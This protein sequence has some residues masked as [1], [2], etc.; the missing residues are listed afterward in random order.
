MA[1]KHDYDKILT[2][3]TVIL[4]KLNDGEALSVK[5][6]AEE[7]NTS[8]RTI[9][10]DFNERLAS[11]PIYQEGKKWKMQDG[12]RVE[13]TKSLE[14]EI[15]LDII[16][17]ITEGIGGTF[18]TKAQKLL[19]KIKN[20][21]FNPIYT[22]LNIEDVSD[23]FSEIQ[24]LETAIK[25]KR[26]VQ[27]SYDNERNDVYTT[28]IQPLKIVNFEGFWY[29]I[30][31]RKDVLKKY[32]LKNI[33]NCSLLE[34]T[35][36]SD[37]ELEDLLDNSISVWFQRDNEPFEVKLYADKAATTY[38]KRRTLPTQ[39]IDSLNSNGTMEFSIRITHEMEILPI[40]KYWIPHLHVIEPIWL[41]DIIQKDIEIYSNMLDNI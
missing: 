40:I 14:D 21:D 7:F 28:T 1:Y 34:T 38:F 2:R 36:E 10:R 31:L 6:L 24:V 3:L 17:K 22:K 41:R 29:L 4:S 35:F 23:K 8:D 26:E 5:A 11:F 15:V 39:S 19:S 33:S 16:E 37:D 12:F 25:E 9:Q 30:A 32:Y 20:E 27:C 13:K 18:S